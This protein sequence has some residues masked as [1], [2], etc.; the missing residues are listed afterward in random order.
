MVAQVSTA[1]YIL[2]EASTLFLDGFFSHLPLRLYRDIC[3]VSSKETAMTP[4]RFTRR[5]FLGSA[6][7]FAALQSSF[8]CSSG[9]AASP[10]IFAPTWDSLDSHSCPEWYRDAKLGMYFHWGVS[11]VPGWAPRE[12]G[13]PYA[14][15]YW[16]SMMDPKNPTWRY[17][18]EKYG[19]EFAYD[20]FI[21]QFRAE[22]YHPEEWVLFAKRSGARY[23]FVN[24]KHHDGYCLWPTKY[25]RRNAARMGPKR[26]LISPLVKAAR[27]EDLKVGFYYSFYEWFNPLYTGTAFPYTGLVFFRDYVD[28]F[29]LP[30]VRELMDRYH[31]DFL[32]FDGEWDHPAEYW[33][34]RDLVAYYYNQASE[35]GQEVL[36]ND[37]FGKGDR[38]KHGDVFNVEYHYD[39]TS[40]G[41]LTHPWS[42]WRGIARTFGFN[43]DTSPEEC[44]SPK[45]LIHM[46]VHGVCRNGNFD[47]NVGPTAAGD[48]TELERTPLLHLG[49]WLRVNGEGIYGTRPWKVQAEGDIRFT[50]KGNTVYAIF[51]AWPGEVFRVRSVSPPDGS[52]IS[53]LGIPG[54]LEWRRESQGFTAFFPLHRSRPSECAYAWTLKIPVA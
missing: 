29:M 4:H 20:D 32:Y 8:P 2:C 35:R 39:G 1:L 5:S 31:P 7:G 17:H 36:V 19:N 33:K 38:G 28:D 16:H 21:P 10:S 13:T 27:R 42:F 22:R 12:G 11:S 24:T 14:E 40:E 3:C 44:L 26:D 48:I 46:F 34:S 25:T 23:I 18:R 45:E 53:M 37:R 30:Q 52:A 54:A 6:A 41:L 15:W 50:T 9:G 49:D 43:R 51:L 47:I